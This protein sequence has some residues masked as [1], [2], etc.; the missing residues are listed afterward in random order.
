MMEK[1]SNPPVT[2]KKKS[3]K[4]QFSREQK[5]IEDALKAFDI[6][7]CLTEANVT[8]TADI[9]GVGKVQYRILSYDENLALNNKLTSDGVTNL[10]ERGLCVVAEMMHRAD[11]KTTPEKLH[12]LSA[13]KTNRLI[14]VLGKKAGFL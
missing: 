2:A 13:G 3:F 5:E 11:G 6:D 12:K 7:T 9:E 4:D 8:Y 10:G 14:N 1:A